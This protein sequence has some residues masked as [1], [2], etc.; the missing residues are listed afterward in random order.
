MDKVQKL[1]EKQKAFCRYYVFDWNATQ[2]AIK[3]GYSEKTARQIAN[4]TLTKPYIKAY[5]K[6]LCSDDEK[7]MGISKR[8]ILA[9]HM[10][11][12]FSSISNLHD[13]WITRKEFDKLTEE[14]KACIQEIS[15]KTN[16]VFDQVEKKPIEVEYVKVKLYDK[17][18]SLD[19]ISKLLGYDAPTKIEMTVNP[20]FDL[21]KRAS[22][23]D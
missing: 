9:E 1:T 21:M 18:K 8:L 23:N 22:S 13:T 2:A 19:A 12:A 14:Q 16:T 6:E 10:K 3:A 11:L 17:Q 7:Y 20:F 5:I 4:E 15:T